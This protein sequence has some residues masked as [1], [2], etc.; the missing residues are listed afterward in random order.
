MID[1]PTINIR[2]CD[3][4]IRFV[5]QILASINGNKI[6]IEVGGLTRLAEPGYSNPLP[7][8]GTASETANCPYRQCF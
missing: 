6:W 3:F 2:M 8:S 1:E 5:V 4:V 7:D